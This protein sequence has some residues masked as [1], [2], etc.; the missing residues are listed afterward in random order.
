MQALSY[1][2][3]FRGWIWIASGFWVALAWRYLGYGGEPYSEAGVF[4]DETRRGGILG[5]I[6]VTLGRFTAHD[7]V[8]VAF[9][10]GLR[11]RTLGF[12]LECG[13]FARAPPRSKLMPICL[14]YVV[15]KKLEGGLMT[16]S[17]LMPDTEDIDGGC[18]RIER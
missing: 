12:D 14:D 18:L 15:G 11:T 8:K 2:A 4:G 1:R 7:G 9:G 5:G 16:A 17:L 13:G 10:L 6:K 3:F